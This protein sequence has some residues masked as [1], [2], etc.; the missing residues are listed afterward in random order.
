MDDP[1]SWDFP[2]LFPPLTPP[3]P[4]STK[5]VV[6]DDGFSVGSS[7]FDLPW[8]FGHNFARAIGRELVSGRGAWGG[9]QHHGREGG[10]I[11]EEEDDRGL[12]LLNSAFGHMGNGD[13]GIMIAE[14][15]E[16]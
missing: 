9:D 7:C 5:A 16:E 10:G 12:S 15:C 1:F 13:G 6:P 4:C 3:R 8:L 11:R 14:S 2:G